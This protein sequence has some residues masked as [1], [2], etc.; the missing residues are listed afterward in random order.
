MYRKR[1]NELSSFAEICLQG[2]LQWCFEWLR[3]RPRV[4]EFVQNLPQNIVVFA[5]GKLGGRELN[6]SSDVDIVFAYADE[7]EFTHK[8]NFLKHQ[9]SI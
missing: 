2:T 3:S 8:N 6:F 5:L 1:L 9:N 4:S 7:D